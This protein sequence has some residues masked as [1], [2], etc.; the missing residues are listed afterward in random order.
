MDSQSHEDRVIQSF[1]KFVN[2]MERPYPSPGQI[3]YRG[4]IQDWP[5]IPSMAR[6][7]KWRTVYFIENCK[8]HEKPWNTEGSKFV[9]YVNETI[10]SMQK[11]REL[12]LRFIR[13]SSAWLSTDRPSDFVEWYYL[14]QHHGVPT[15]LLD[16]TCDP[17]VALWFAVAGGDDKDGY[18]YTYD[19]S[20]SKTILDLGQLVRT[21]Q[22]KSTYRSM[23][24][25]QWESRVIGAL[26]SG[27]RY[28]TETDVVPISPRV[29]NSRQSRQSSFFTLHVPYRF[30]ENHFWSERDYP[31][32]IN[33]N[34]L[35]LPSKYKF[36]IPG[37]DKALFR[38]YLMRMGRHL[39]SIFPDMDHLGAGLF[40][41]I[42]GSEQ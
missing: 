14:A 24:P 38:R 20:E 28:R 37:K 27:E 12:L 21:S 16:W 2:R 11:E 30:L 42:F 5:L 26:L 8:N 7:M 41:E 9:Y 29:Y 1:H 23:R 39:W 32:D 4:Q 3:W 17:L 36:C 10:D 6:Y 40:F 25:E 22:G 31:E 34:V 35:A 33:H 18:V 13:E 15:R 19:V